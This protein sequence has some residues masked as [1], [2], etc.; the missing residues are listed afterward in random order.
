MEHAEAIQRETGI[1]VYKLEARRRADMPVLLRLIQKF[2]KEKLFADESI[3]E[4]VWQ[5][6]LRDK[7]ILTSD[8]QQAKDENSLAKARATKDE[9]LSSGMSDAARFGYCKRSG[10]MNRKDK[11]LLLR[12]FCPDCRG[13]TVNQSP[14]DIAVTVD[15][16]KTRPEVLELTSEERREKVLSAKQQ[17]PSASVRDLA[18]LTNIPRKTVH[19]ILKNTIV[20]TKPVNSV[21]VAQF[22][23]ERAE[24]LPLLQEEAKIYLKRRTKRAV[25]SS[26]NSPGS[27]GVKFEAA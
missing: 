6:Y 20:K 25:N 24:R 27:E 16:T 1:D 17:N 14:T 5:E 11:R 19:D 8:E 13:I 26:V 10:C 21:E 3:E 18:R 4:G 9:L 15:P 2:R 22:L 12:G 7:G 23:R